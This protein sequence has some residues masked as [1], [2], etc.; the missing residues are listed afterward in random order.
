MDVGTCLDRDVGIYDGGRNIGMRVGVGET[1]GANQGNFVGRELGDGVGSGVRGLV[2]LGVEM[3]IGACV[4]RNVGPYV[5][6]ARCF[7]A[8]GNHGWYR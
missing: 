3:A 5:G 8:R 6:W 4:V 7:H 1:V 2:G